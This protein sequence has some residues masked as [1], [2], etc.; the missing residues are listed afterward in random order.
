MDRIKKLENIKL[1]KELDF[2]ESEFNYKN[3]VI[4]EADTSFLKTVNAY[5][6]IH[7]ELK[8]LFDEKINRKI[9]EMLQKK[10]QEENDQSESELANDEFDLATE[11]HSE[12]QEEKEEIVQNEEN[13]TDFRNEKL[14][15]LYREIAKL[16]H[17]DKVKNNK[18]NSLYLKATSFYD[19]NN[20][21]GIYAICNELEIYYE[22]DENDN[23]FLVEK[24]SNLKQRISFL[25][26]TF[27]WKWK[28]TDDSKERETIIIRYISSQLS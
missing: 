16:T 26:S 18:L 6:D 10:T 3:E 9:E 19:E 21:F 15:K 24:I 7:P 8:K 5:L 12:Q 11:L 27:T 13:S 23:V 28:H 17:P 20:I 1:M 2:I 14:K 4:C 25:E 22:I